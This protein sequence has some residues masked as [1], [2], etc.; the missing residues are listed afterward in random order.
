M[1]TNQKTISEIKKEMEENKNPIPEVKEEVVDSVAPSETPEV[2]D[3]IDYKAELE[4]A[5][6]RLRKA[7]FSLYKNK[8]EAK[9]SKE[10]ES[11]DEVPDD[12][13]EALLE[14]KLNERLGKL[15]TQIVGRVLEDELS[16]I[17]TN[18]DEQ[19]L[20]RLHYENSVMKS[21]MDRESVR[22][23]LE[24]AYLIANAPKLRKMNTELSASIKANKSKTNSS[25]GTSQAD[26]PN[27]EVDYKKHFSAHD[28]EFIQK[29]KWT[30]EQIKKAYEDKQ[31]FTP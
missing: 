6:E 17:S 25:A 3:D 20:I 8:K 27:I 19:K 12:K 4:K 28:W 7:E 21:G 9:V 14:Q 11:M 13:F 23:D 1:E 26:L 22:A 31:K 2:V 29:R 30:K 10:D 24:K 18:P 15:E 5:N 16:S